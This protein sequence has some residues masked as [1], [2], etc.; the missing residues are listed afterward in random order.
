MKKGILTFLI[1]IL[2][3]LC[4]GSAF[5]GVYVNV[6]LLKP[7]APPVE[8]TQAPDT[9]DDTDGGLPVLPNPDTVWFKTYAVKVK[10]TS[11]HKETFFI[12]Y[13]DSSGCGT[14][15]WTDVEAGGYLEKTVRVVDSV[16]FQCIDES[17][18][19]RIYVDGVLHVGDTISIN[20]DTVIELILL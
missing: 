5:L 8:D 9:E 3:I 13:Q 7:E 4:L 2:S 15:N 16:R 1:L 6:F 18:D 17:I 10:I 12:T 11:A 19:Y 14:A 20:K